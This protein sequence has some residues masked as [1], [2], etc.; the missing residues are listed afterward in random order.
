MA[1]TVVP[2]A[3]MPLHRVIWLG[4]LFNSGEV[5]FGSD[6]VLTGL[7]VLAGPLAI[8]PLLSFRWRLGDCRCRLWNSCSFWRPR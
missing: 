7:L 4:W 8:V 3:E 1:A 2:P 5:A 6:N